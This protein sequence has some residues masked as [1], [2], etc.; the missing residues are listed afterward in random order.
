HIEHHKTDRGQRKTDRRDRKTDRTHE[1]T[2]RKTGDKRRT[3][4]RGKEGR[5]TQFNRWLWESGKFEEV[6]WPRHW[7]WPGNTEW[8]KDPTTKRQMNEVLD[9]VIDPVNGDWALRYIITDND[10]RSPQMEFDMSPYQAGEGVETL[11]FR[12]DILLGEKELDA[13]GNW[14]GNWINGRICTDRHGGPPGTWR[15]EPTF[16]R[17]PGLFGSEP[18]NDK[19]WTLYTAAYWQGGGLRLWTRYNPRQGDNVLWGW[20]YDLT[21]PLPEVV[22]LEPGKWYT[23]VQA[24]ELNQPGQVDGKFKVWVRESGGPLQAIQ[25]REVSTELP[26]NEDS[27]PAADR[28]DPEQIEFRPDEDPPKDKVGGLWMRFWYSQAGGDDP[29]NNHRGVVHVD[30]VRLQRP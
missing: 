8:W 19:T 26:F 15:F 23:I 3:P 20:F 4:R 13:D 11:V 2:P 17:L 5:K 21:V 24:V 30:N 29:P 12:Y 22:T 6:D 7:E 14:T 16:G 27:V 28:Q 1:R 9:R 10:S 18:G 25:L